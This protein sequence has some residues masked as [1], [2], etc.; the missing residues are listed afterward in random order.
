MRWDGFD[1][2]EAPVEARGIITQFGTN[3]VHENLEFKMVHE[4][5]VGLVGGSGSGKSVL[6]NTLL[7]LKNPEG[8]KV[9][10]YGRDRATLSEEERARIN[11]KICLLYTSPSPRDA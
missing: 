4:E 3:V 10:Y 2:S 6:M 5:I 7:G 11:N 1:R 8:G 9:Y